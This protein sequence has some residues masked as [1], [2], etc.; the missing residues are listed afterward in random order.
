MRMF[1]VDRS[2]ALQYSEF[3]RLMEQVLT[4]CCP[5]RFLQYFVNY[6]LHSFASVVLQLRS[7]RA[8]FDAADRD[9][10]GSLSRPEV[11]AAL[12]HFGFTVPE[13]VCVTL[14]AAFDE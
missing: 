1:D 4:F 13:H 12:R 9:R 5:S 10:S 3:E 6:S 7:W 14:M 2:G 11:F 8:H